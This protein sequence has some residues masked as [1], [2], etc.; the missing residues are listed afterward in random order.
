MKILNL[1][2][3]LA[4][5]LD[6]KSIPEKNRLIPEHWVDMFALTAFCCQCNGKLWRTDRGD[7]GSIT[8]SLDNLVFD[9]NGFAVTTVGIQPAV[10]DPMTFLNQESVRISFWVSLTDKLKPEAFWEA[11]V[12]GALQCNLVGHPI[13]F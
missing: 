3:L 2:T 12:N 10:F 4:S 8:V 11:R 1:E 5:K 9:Y 6:I 13:V 7:G